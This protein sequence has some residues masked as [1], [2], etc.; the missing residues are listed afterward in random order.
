MYLFQNMEDSLII[1]KNGVCYHLQKCIYL[2]LL[3]ETANPLWP[4][5]FLPPQDCQYLA[6]KV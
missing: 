3:W 5:A 6:Y 2:V 1:D 4:N